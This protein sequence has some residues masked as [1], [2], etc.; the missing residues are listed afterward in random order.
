[1]RECRRLCHL[2]IN[3]QPPI[4]QL[5]RINAGEALGQASSDLRHLK[6]VRESVMEDVPFGGANDL[7]DPRK[8]PEGRTVE[9]PV[10]IL[11]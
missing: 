4:R 3:Y 11:L 7:S 9:D 5:I 6:G 2:R 8:A 1:M 10:S